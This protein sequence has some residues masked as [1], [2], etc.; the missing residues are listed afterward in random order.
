MDAG[1]GSLGVNLKLWIARIWLIVRVAAN[2][3]GKKA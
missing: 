3:D 2:G 1:T